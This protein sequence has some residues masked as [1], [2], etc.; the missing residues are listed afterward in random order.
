MQFGANHLRHFAPTNLLLKH[1]EKRNGRNAN[2]SSV[3][4]KYV[5]FYSKNFTKNVSTQKFLFILFIL[6]LLRLNQEDIQF[7]NTFLKT[8]GFK[9]PEQGAQTAIYCATNYGLE[10]ESVNYFAE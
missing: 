6:G 10:N 1:M 9:S 3:A 5:K 7:L 8:P 4:H 2:V